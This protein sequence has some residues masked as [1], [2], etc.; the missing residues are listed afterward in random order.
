M[1]STRKSCWYSSS[2]QAMILPV[3]KLFQVHFRW[4]G[5]LACLVLAMS[6]GFANAEM[7]TWTSNGGTYSLKADFVKA[8]AT[9]VTVRDEAGKQRTFEISKL[10]AIDQAYVQGRLKPPTSSAP[11]GPVLAAAVKKV[12]RMKPVLISDM[13]ADPKMEF[14]VADF[15][16]SITQLVHA[17][18]NVG[19]VTAQSGFTF[20]VVGIRL[21]P[22]KLPAQTDVCGFYLES[23]QGSRYPVHL[24]VVQA[25]EDPGVKRT[26][27]DVRSMEFSARE[28]GDLIENTYVFMIPLIADFKTYR[29]GFTEVDKKAAAA[30]KP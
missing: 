18:K 26:L 2:D 17:P 9:D 24:L 27:R 15:T 10:S 11:A 4:L 7:R 25:E 8:T 21:K 29:L 12:E 1:E 22:E 3:K 23:P 30:A 19:G 28:E 14:A 6:A 13:A 16:G 5:G 20:G